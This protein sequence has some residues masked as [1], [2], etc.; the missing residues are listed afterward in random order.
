MGSPNRELRQQVRTLAAE[1]VLIAV[2][3]RRAA[4]RR[5][6]WRIIVCSCA[7]G[8]ILGSAATLTLIAVVR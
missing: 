4:N 8:V 1:R 6:F 7:I 2:E 3:G 5:L